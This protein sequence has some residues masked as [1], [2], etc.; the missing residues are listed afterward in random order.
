M[1][2]WQWPIFRA[3]LPGEYRQRYDVSL[4]CSGWERVG[5]PR[6]NHQDIHCCELAP[7]GQESSGAAG[8]TGRRHRRLRPSDT[9]PRT[10]SPRPCWRHAHAARTLA[11]RQREGPNRGRSPHNQPAQLSDRSKTVTKPAVGSAANATATE[12]SGAGSPQRR[13]RPHRRVAG[14]TD[15]PPLTGCPGDADREARSCSGR[16][17]SLR[18]PV[19]R[20]LIGCSIAQPARLRRA[21]AQID[22][23]RRRRPLRAAFESVWLREGDSNPRPSGYEPDELPLLH[24]ALSSHCNA[25]RSRRPPRHNGISR[26]PHSRCLSTDRTSP[27]ACLAR[28]AGAQDDRIDA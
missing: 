16:S 28:R 2:S 22:P 18:P 20:K 15:G 10:R 26:K 14:Y 11:L 13:L 24:P 25:R 27:L 6:S 7:C 9:S 12:H 19:L 8:R 21:A 5:P 23:D 17:R 4:P 3:Q 1:S